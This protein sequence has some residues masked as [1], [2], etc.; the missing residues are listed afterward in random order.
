M[1]YAVRR[2]QEVFV[3]SR[4]IVS[5]SGTPAASVVDEPKLERI[6]LRTIPLAVR[7]SLTTPLTE[8]VPSEGYGPLVSA[9]NARQ[10]EL[11]LPLDVLVLE[12]ELELPLEPP[13]QAAMTAAVAP[14]SIHSSMR[15]RSW[16][17]R[18]IACKSCCRVKPWSWSSKRSAVI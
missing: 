13:P 4:V 15:R 10:L 5:V 11:E 7:M 14:E 12:L 18:S 16:S 17:R 1:A 8:F 6:S 2:A 9:G 3:S